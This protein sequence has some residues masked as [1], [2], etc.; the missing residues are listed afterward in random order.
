MS[1]ANPAE[2]SERDRRLDEILAA[3]LAA[4]DA[5]QAAMRDALLAQNADLADEL[6]AFLGADDRVKVLAAPLRAAAAARSPDDETR[7]REPES[8]LDV[9]S[10]PSGVSVESTSGPD[11]DADAAARTTPNGTDACNPI[12]FGTRIRYFG[13]Y[14]LMSVLGRGGMGVVYRARQISLN[15]PVALKMLQAG[16][17]ATEDDLRRFQNEAE[18]VA[19]L[20]H[21]HIVPILEV[22]QHEDQRY[23]SMKLIGGQSLD[24]RLERIHL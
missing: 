16:V 22:G 3:I 23:F 13:D 7:D 5:G 9:A 17:L 15:R 2:I 6:K 21:P 20:D 12:E 19:M 18:A 1:N 10:G 4:E 8:T 14:E 24:R 11:E